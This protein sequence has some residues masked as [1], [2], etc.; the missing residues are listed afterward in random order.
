MT[1]SRISR[2]VLV[3]SAGAMIM[4]LTACPPSTHPL[5]PLTLLPTD[6]NPTCVVTSTLFATWF[7]SSSTPIPAPVNTAFA[8]ANSVNFPNTPNCSFYQWAMQDF[9]K[10]PGDLELVGSGHY[11]EG[12]EKQAD[13]KWRIVHN[14]N[15]R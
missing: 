7:Q 14:Y 12:Y 2:V 8:P 10:F 15:Y 4:A 11:H 13:G 1:T 6:P 3:A 9:L 5:N